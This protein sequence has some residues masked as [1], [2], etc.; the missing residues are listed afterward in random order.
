V[1]QGNHKGIATARRVGMEWVGETDKYYG[2]FLQ[3]Y[4][5]TKP[6]LDLPEFDAHLG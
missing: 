2:L 1:R 6:D 3:I 5:L 4:R